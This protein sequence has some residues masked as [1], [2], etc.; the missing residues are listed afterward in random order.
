M[1]SGYS[2]NSSDRFARAMNS[3]PVTRSGV[4]S[5]GTAPPRTANKFEGKPPSSVGENPNDATASAMLTKPSGV[6]ASPG[7]NTVP[8]VPAKTVPTSVAAIVL[9]P[10]A[11]P[12]RIQL[13]CAISK[14]VPAGAVRAAPAGD[15]RKVANK[16]SGSAMLS[17][18]LPAVPNS[19]PTCRR[20]SAKSPV[21]ANVAQP[22]VSV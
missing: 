3:A 22:A 19:P 18:P 4:P 16:P 17:N 7:A 1:S 9:A 11:A 14:I 12:N 6:V 5:S 20:G 15:P 2:K 13:A 21:P 10:P 8:P